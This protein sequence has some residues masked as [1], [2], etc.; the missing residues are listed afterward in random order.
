[1]GARRSSRKTRSIG[2]CWGFCVPMPTNQTKERSGELT[3]RQDLWVIE[4]LVTRLPTYKGSPLRL[5][6]SAPRVRSAARSL[7]TVFRRIGKGS[8]AAS[9]PGFYEVRFDLSCTTQVLH[10]GLFSNLRFKLKNTQ[11]RGHF[12]CSRASGTDFARCQPDR[13]ST[14]DSSGGKAEGTAA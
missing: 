6:I 2:L 14:H 5:A 12:L 7:A 3:A 13:G 1:M 4:R 10:G 9:D 11:C 8:R